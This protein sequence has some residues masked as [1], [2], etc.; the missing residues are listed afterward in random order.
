MVKGYVCTHHAKRNTLPL[1][2]LLPGCVARLQLFPVLIT[3]TTYFSAFVSRR[4]SLFCFRSFLPSPFSLH[5]GDCVDVFVPWISTQASPACVSQ[6]QAWSPSRLIS[7]PSSSLSA[8]P[9][10]TGA[11]SLAPSLSSLP[12][13]QLTV[14]REVGGLPTFV[15]SAQTTTQT[16]QP[17]SSSLS[18]PHTGSSGSW[19]AAILLAPAEVGSR[20]GWG[21]PRFSDSPPQLLLLFPS[22]PRHVPA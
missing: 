7:S 17:L 5:A 21:G 13:P 14:S 18:P 10:N 4:F 16:E 12:V 6:L 22:G 1:R 15:L 20:A 3:T 8:S 2:C 11:G 19:F 9:F